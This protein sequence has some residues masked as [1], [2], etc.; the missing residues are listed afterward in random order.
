MSWQEKWPCFHFLYNPLLTC[1]HSLVFLHWMKSGRHEK[2]Q[3]WPISKSMQNKNVCWRGHFGSSGFAVPG[4]PSKH[5]LSVTNTMTCSQGFRQPETIGWGQW[6]PL[7][8]QSAGAVSSRAHLHSLEI[9]IN[10][11]ASEVFAGLAEIGVILSSRCA[12]SAV[13]IGATS[14]W[15]RLLHC[16]RSEWKVEAWTRA[17]AWELVWK[18]AHFCTWQCCYCFLQTWRNI[19][20]WKSSQS[21]WDFAADSRG[22]SVLESRDDVAWVYTL[23]LGHT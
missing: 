17:G 23:Y 1:I 18:E 7:P 12:W 3:K 9:S 8:H 14:I 21:T 13:V 20:Q 2:I 10:H 4:K 6:L 5:E 11:V 19:T 15:S 16:K 22:R